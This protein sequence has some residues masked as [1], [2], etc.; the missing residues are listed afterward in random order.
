M[1]ERKAY[2]IANISELPNEPNPRSMCEKSNEHAIAFFGLHSPFSYL[3]KS[4]FKHDG[5]SYS[6]AEQ[7]IQSQKAD[8]YN[9]DAA[10]TMIMLA[11]DP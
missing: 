5:R 3:Y 2:T 4:S 9:D 7:C 10:K 6:C 1:V 11:C 8:K